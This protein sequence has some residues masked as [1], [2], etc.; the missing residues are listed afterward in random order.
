MKTR[1][2]L[3]PT[4]CMFVLGVTAI[5]QQPKQ[6]TIT[7]IDAPHAGTI[8]GYGTEAIAICPGGQI[9]GFYAGY[10]NSIHA[11]VRATDGTITTLDAPGAGWGGGI[12]TPAAPAI[13]SST[14]VA[15]K[16]V[17]SLCPICG[18]DSSIS[19]PVR[20]AFTPTSTKLMP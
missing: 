17:R 5:A 2:S 19:P 3:F 18:R 7:T 4:I 16:I 15:R 10:S 20:S 8:G 9:A 6:P 12:E 14:P 11:Y 1:Q 13:I